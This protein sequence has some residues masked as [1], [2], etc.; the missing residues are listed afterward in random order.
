[1]DKSNRI[2]TTLSAFCDEVALPMGEI[3]LQR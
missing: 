3:G 1:M 2:A